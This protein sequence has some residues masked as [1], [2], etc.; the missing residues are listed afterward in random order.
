MWR[1][2]GI[3]EYRPDPN[4]RFLWGSVLP[5]FVIRSRNEKKIPTPLKISLFSLI[6]QEYRTI[7]YSGSLFAL[8]YIIL[9]FW[10][11]LKK[12]VLKIDE[13]LPLLNETLF[14]KSL[15]SIKKERIELEEEIC[16]IISKTG[17]DKGSVMTEHEESLIN[18]L[19]SLHKQIHHVMSEASNL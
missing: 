9:L 10:T 2:K 16:S 6:V 15:N 8:Y 13:L 4:D 19:E 7:P 14:L 1:Y 17:A 3:L 11:F 5:A 18:R 12:K